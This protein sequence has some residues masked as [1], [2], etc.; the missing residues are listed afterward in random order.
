MLLRKSNAKGKYNSKIAFEKKLEKLSKSKAKGNSKVN[1][2]KLTAE[3]LTLRE[4][5]VCDKVLRIHL[6]KENLK[7]AYKGTSAELNIFN[8]ES[9]VDKKPLRHSNKT[10]TNTKQPTTLTYNKSSPRKMV[11][12]NGKVSKHDPDDIFIKKLKAKQNG[13][14][15]Y[16][17][18]VPYKSISEGKLNYKFH[19]LVNDVKNMQLPT[20]LWKIKVIIRH[21]KI[22]AIIFTNKAEL[23]RS[24]SFNS[25]D[26]KY[27][28]IID[29][30]PAL[31]LGSP[32]RVNSC[33]EI[34]VLLNIMENI[35]KNNSMI[36]YK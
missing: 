8:K 22:A 5:A 7:S 35:D 31:L 3:N 9:T 17:K 18:Q 15:Y 4:V 26:D 2:R 25:D 29:N 11:I 23:E 6:R 21:N 28:I 30:K 14:I 20:P 27:H 34:E 13:K 1:F 36:M 24:L 10:T 12:N 33:N 16:L 19:Q 32:G